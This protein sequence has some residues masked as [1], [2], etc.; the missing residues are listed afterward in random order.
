MLNPPGAVHCERYVQSPARRHPARRDPRAFSLI[1][2]LIV[3]VI[4]VMLTSILLPSLRRAKVITQQTI[5]ASNLRQISIAMQYYLEDNNST[6]PCSQDPV[7]TSP[8]YWLWMGRGWRALVGPYISESISAENPSVLFCP[9]DSAAQ[10]QYESTSYAYSM[11]F[12]HSPKQ[13]DAMSSPADTYSNPVPSIAQQE[14]DVAF[15][16]QKILMGEW[17]SNH[18]PALQ[19]NGWWCWE[20][21]RNFLLADGSIRF[22]DAGRIRPARDEFPNPCLTV[23]GVAGRDLH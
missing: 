16:A 17:T 18:E 14:I 2:L 6:Y 22:V 1:E 15:P 4:I 23:H 19:D 8:F 21:S 20:G 5:C 7:S 3:I 9:S 12:Y 10:T 13:I 11:S